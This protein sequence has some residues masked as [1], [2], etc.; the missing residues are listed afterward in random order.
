[1][2]RIVQIVKKEG[3]NAEMPSLIFGIFRKCEKYRTIRQTSA[4]LCGMTLCNLE[5]VALK[6]QQRP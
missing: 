4:K 3:E 5:T 6:P 2:L 1:M